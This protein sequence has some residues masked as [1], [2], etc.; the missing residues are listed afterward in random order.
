MCCAPVLQPACDLKV[1]QVSLLLQS[2]MLAAVP[3]DLLRLQLFFGVR[4]TGL[5][6]RCLST[7]VKMSGHS[8]KGV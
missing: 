4:A 6:Q 7:A 2:Y 8:C 5:L 1:A 3:T